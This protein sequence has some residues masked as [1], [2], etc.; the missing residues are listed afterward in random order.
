MLWSIV[1]EMM[2]TMFHRFTSTVMSIRTFLL[3]FLGCHSCLSLAAG[4]LSRRG[5]AMIRQHY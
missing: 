3:S 4:S 2:F 1:L 5:P